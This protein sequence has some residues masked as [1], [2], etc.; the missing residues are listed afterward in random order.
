M[1]PRSL[2]ANYPFSDIHPAFTRAQTAAIGLERRNFV[3]FRGRIAID[4]SG[5]PV[6]RN[7]R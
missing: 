6:S 2:Y 1:I 7:N 5:T 4:L 3:H